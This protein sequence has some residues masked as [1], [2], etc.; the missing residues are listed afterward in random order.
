MS[1]PTPEIVQASLA[2]PAG[3]EPQL[4]QHGISL[5][6]LFVITTAAAVLIAGFAPVAQ[7]MV[8]G[9][10]GIGELAAALGGGL[11]GGMQLG[12]ILGMHRYRRLLGAIIGAAVGA[13]VG[14]LVGPLTLLPA[15]LL[16][17]V[18]TAMFI[19]SLLMIG[20]AIVMRPGAR[21]RQ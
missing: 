5:A 20:V 7:R 4:G 12:L 2:E 15:R 1:E 11:F 17:P 10:V 9:K 13:G 3:K 16:Q 6:S 8:E 21:S 19:G 14:L 18:G